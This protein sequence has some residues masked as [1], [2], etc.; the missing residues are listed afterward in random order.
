[1]KNLEDYAN[2][3]AKHLSFDVQYR[4]MAFFDI[5]K[6]ARKEIEIFLLDKGV[7]N[8]KDLL[9]FWS[10]ELNKK[11]ERSVKN[12]IKKRM[13]GLPL[14]YIL[15]KQNF[16]GINFKVNRN[17]L[18]PRP[19]TEE[20]VDWAL[21]SALAMKEKKI[22]VVDVGTGS[23][24]ILIS[25]L[26]NLDKKIKLEKIWAID[27]DSRILK[28]AKLNQK[29]ILKKRF[30][31]KFL[32]KNLL[33]GFDYNSKNPLFV[34]ANLP[35]LSEK[36]FESISPEVASFEPK[37]AL[38]SGKKGTEL[39]EKLIKEI[40]VLKQKNKKTTFEVFLELSP[41]TLKK[42]KESLLKKIKK[43]EIKKDLCGKN[44]FLRLSL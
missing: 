11:Q 33:E 41:E 25:F 34:L 35:Y 7:F 13:S 20:L 26:K 16:F 10:K 17:T 40:Q 9:F 23:G 5:L 37:T 18:I 4:S 32:K 28:V 31:I 2:R 24:C 29:N 36:E 42:I 14:A 3:L 27:Q 44:R 43:I 21:E 6:T 30:E 22:S 1:M 8:Q 12:L 39:I 19:E 15:K 38:V